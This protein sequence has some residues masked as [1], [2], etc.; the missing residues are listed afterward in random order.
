MEEARALSPADQELQTLRAQVLALSEA[1]RAARAQLDALQAQVAA[2]T[3][4]EAVARSQLKEAHSLTRALQ[5]KARLESAEAE[6]RL[7]ESLAAERT[8]RAKAEADLQRASNELRQQRAR[9]ESELETL[10]ALFSDLMRNEA[11]GRQRL[12]RLQHQVS[13]LSTQLEEARKAAP[14]SVPVEA[15]EIQAQIESLQR[16]LASERGR[17]KAHAE[18]AAAEVEWAQDRARSATQAEEHAKD[19]IEAAER[20]LSA[21]RQR[22]ADAEEA[23]DRTASQQAAQVAAARRELDDERAAARAALEKRA[24]EL[25]A[26]QEE[27]AK[28]KEAASQLAQKVKEHGELAAVRRDDLAD[29]RLAGQKMAVRI[30]EL[31][32]ELAARASQED[33]GALRANLEKVERER[34]AEAAGRK[35]AEDERDRLASDHHALVAQARV[36]NGRAAA[37]I[38]ALNQE[39]ARSRQAVDEARQ[40]REAVEG[41]ERRAQRAEQE[42]DAALRTG[43]DTAQKAAEAE[44]VRTR[45][46]AEL[47]TA[48]QS[49]AQARREARERVAAAEREMRESVAKSEQETEGLRSELASLRAENVDLQIR[50]QQAERLADDLAPIAAT[51]TPR[52]MA[53][54]EL[55]AGRLEEAERLLVQEMASAPDDASLHLQLGRLHYARDASAAA[56]AELSRAM[57]LDASDHLAPLLL[58]R[59][60]M[61]RGLRKPARDAF[62][63]ALRRKPDSI[64]A[65]DGLLLLKA[66]TIWR[67]AV[68]ALGVAAVA[69]MLVLRFR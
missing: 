4:R 52:R 36:D 66:Q 22:L 47:E 25:R 21:F 65:R 34:A 16:E 67:G 41:L 62:R 37:E 12:E 39:V 28:E 68:A 20:E 32:R 8:A 3:R 45:L 31:E 63:E 64:E 6:A 42:R 27:L 38:A 69:L 13:E 5:E 49:I 9:P 29:E 11:Q 61:R 14:V 58:A 50:H 26:L 48:Q 17:A 56:E 44:R 15:A 59:V 7:S 24:D 43:G 33:V 2:L 54:L 10:R 18:R 60:Q 23:R 19:R 57:A 46:Q 55:E 35:A 51:V 1:E 53:A 30:A 40:L